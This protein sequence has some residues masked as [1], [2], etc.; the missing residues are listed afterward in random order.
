MTGVANYQEKYADKYKR[1]KCRYIMIV[2]S[3]WMRD[4]F[5]YLTTYVK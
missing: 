4:V 3:S 5:G 1:S 2:L